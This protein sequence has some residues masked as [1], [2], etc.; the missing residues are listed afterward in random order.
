MW[1]RNLQKKRPSTRWLH[2]W[3][4]SDIQRRVNTCYSQT[5]PKNAEEGTCPITFYEASITLVPKPKISHKKENL[6]AKISVEHRYKNPQKKLA[7]WIQL[8]SGSYTMIKWD[9]SQGYKDS[10]VSTDQSDKHINTGKYT[11][12]MMI[13]IDAENTFDKVQHPVLIEK[14]N[15]P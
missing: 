9:L 3:I 7:N 4:L 14:K 1:F 8:Y 10:S 5:L 12:H 6:Q 13:S 11:N 2:R 15:S